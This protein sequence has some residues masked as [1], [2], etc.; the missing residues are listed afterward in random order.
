MN[1]KINFGLA[2]VVILLWLWLPLNPL[3]AQLS[4]PARYEK[5]HK[6]GDR[7]FTL[8]SMGEQGI[9]LIRDKQKYEKGNTFWELIILDS[10]LQEVWL[11]DLIIESR[12]NLVGHEYRDH[13]LYFLF[14]LGDTDQG[15][16][17]IIKVDFIAQQVEEH[18]YE[19]ELTIKLTHFNVVENQAILAGEVSGEP[20]ILLYNLKNDQ[21]KII[22]GLLLSNSELL[23]VR[24]NVNNTFNVLFKEKKSKTAKRLIAKTFDHTGV[25]LLDDVIEVD[26][27]KTILTALTSTL[28]R[29]ELMIMG[30][31]GETGHTQASGIFTVQVDPYND[32]KITYFDFAQLAH[33]LDYLSP[34]RAARVKEQSERNRSLGK[35]PAF[36]THVLPVRLEETTNGFLFYF[37]GY[38][39][40]DNTSANRWSST[41][42]NNYPYSPFGYSNP[43]RLYNSPYNYGYPYGYGNTTSHETKMLQGCLA[44]FDAQGKLIADHGVKLDQQK[45]AQAD[46][47]SDFIYTPS[48][49]TIVFEKEKEINIQVTQTDG[50]PLL[51]EKTKIQ[52]KSPNEMI[53][54]EDGNNGVIRFWYGKSL[55]LSGYQTIKS[56]DAASRDVFYLNKLILE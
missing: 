23:E 29:D 47:V 22:P 12:Y 25:Q 53:R 51:N 3:L 55:Y 34:K 40:S 13:L 24:V 20:T 1:L 11:K 54:K 19:P 31:W 39:S 27:D 14:R 38:F 10:A 21:V 16:L 32:Q 4:Q 45:M 56:D 9:A 52:L 33:Y 6:S 30:I 37:E 26:P 49:T 36:S 35:I 17:K 8:I 48:R 28:I 15:K 5:E 18:R 7:D 41:S 2:N 50:I 42:P 43:F 46:Q 44:V